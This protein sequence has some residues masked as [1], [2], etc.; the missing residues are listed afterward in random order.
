MIGA[1]A[2]TG[3]V[4]EGEVRLARKPNY[5]C[6]PPPPSYCFN[7]NNNGNGKGKVRLG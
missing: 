2:G 5:G 6:A 4:G 1:W 3:T 7:D